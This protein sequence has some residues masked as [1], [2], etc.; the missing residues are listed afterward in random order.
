MMTL[1]LAWTID[2]DGLE[3]WRGLDHVH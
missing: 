2:A 3:A 1:P